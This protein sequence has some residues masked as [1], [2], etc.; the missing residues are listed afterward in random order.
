MQNFRPVSDTRGVYDIGATAYLRWHPSVERVKLRDLQPLRF[1]PTLASQYPRWGSRCVDCGAKVQIR[2][3]ISVLTTV[4]NK[5]ANLQRHSATKWHVYQTA[6]CL[7]NGALD[8]NRN[9]AQ[10]NHIESLSLAQ[11]LSCGR[12]IVGPIQADGPLPETSTI[13]ES[14]EISRQPSCLSGLDQYC[15]SISFILF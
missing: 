1:S 14:I 7:V 4:H 12:G 9:D 6:Q 5:V 3:K 15:T 13:G 10:P 11:V 8:A 2:R